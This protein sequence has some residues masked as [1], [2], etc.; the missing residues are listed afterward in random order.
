MKNRDNAPYRMDSLPYNFMTITRGNNAGVLP[1]RVDDDNKLYFEFI[2][3]QVGLGDI[4]F[5]ARAYFD[6]ECVEPLLNQP[7]KI[8]FIELYTCDLVSLGKADPYKPR[9]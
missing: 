5:E 9:V 1:E 2:G 6:P 3:R 8:G 7:G 4:P